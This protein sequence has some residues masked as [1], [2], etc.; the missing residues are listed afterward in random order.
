MERR[1][2]HAD[3]WQ[4]VIELIAFKSGDSFRL[5]SAEPISG[6]C[7][8][9]AFKLTMATGE[10]F[11]V[12]RNSRAL[13]P[14]FQA[15]ICGLQA[16]AETKKVRVP[17]P[18]GTVQSAEHAFLVMSWISHGPSHGSTHERLGRELAELHRHSAAKEFGF[19]IDNF[20]GSSPQPNDWSS[21][22]K[23]FFVE[24]RIE[25]QLR[26]AKSNGFGSSF[27][28]P[29]RLLKN[30]EDL[31]SDSPKPSLIHGDL[32]SGNFIVDSDGDPVLIDPAPYWADREAEFGIVT[33]FGGFKESFFAA[34]R[35]SY[36]FE[37]GFERRLLAYQ[38]YH[39][40]NHLNLF[41]ESYLAQVQKIIAK[42]S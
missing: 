20:I 15:E 27:R 17:T 14:M 26:I 18:L 21:S 4:P 42:I 16:L 7:I 11:F 39:Y 1:M 5:E 37:S 19:E 22:W 12:K 36:P 13:L 9:A 6:G 24:H 33:M 38:L 8:N 30:I 41:G 31:L 3:Q 35:E 40:L 34:Y 23:K 25:Y 32:W 29:K 2:I 28:N 10:T